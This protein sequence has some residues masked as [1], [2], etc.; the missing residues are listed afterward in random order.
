MQDGTLAEKL[1]GLNMLKDSDVPVVSLRE[2]GL[3]STLFAE[4]ANTQLG[5]VGDLGGVCF[6]AFF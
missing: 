4:A 6:L 2:K 1:Q 5:R 3:E